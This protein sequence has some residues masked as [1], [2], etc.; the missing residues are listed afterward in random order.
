MCQLCLNIQR[1]MCALLLLLLLLRD[2]ER[3]RP[4]CLHLMVALSRTPG[5]KRGRGE[6]KKGGRVALLDSQREGE[7]G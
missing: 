2:D 3:H 7:R 4:I 5:I 6:G 1:A